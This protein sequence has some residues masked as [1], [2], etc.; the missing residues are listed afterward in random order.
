MKKTVLFLVTLLLTGYFGTAQVLY[1]EDFDNLT[2]GDV[3]TDFTG[4]Q[5]GQGG[6]YTLSQSLAVPADADN[7]YFKI[8]TEPNKGKVLQTTALPD[9]GINY[10]QTRGLDVLWSNRTTGN[11]VLKVE[12]DF[13]TGPHLSINGQNQ[14][15]RILS[16]NDFNSTNNNLITQVSYTP[17]LKRFDLRPGTL[18]MSPS[19]FPQLNQNTWYT[20]VFYIDYTNQKTYFLIPSLGV[21]A[22]YDHPDSIL[23][24]SSLLFYHS[25]SPNQTMKSDYKYDNISIS[26]VN[27]V[28][29]SVQDFISDKFSL[30]PNPSNNIIN[31]TNNKNIGVEQVTIFDVNG[32]LIKTKAFNKEHNVQIDVSAFAAGAYLVHIETNKGT[33]VKK[34][35]KN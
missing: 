18:N 3:G 26:A 10:I 17:S 24:P 1:S 27:T 28:P 25:T 7:K 11:D 6:W 35:I 16:N 30:Y 14:V 19:P 12:Y 31:I 4:Q 8:V 15:L 22:V 23:L 34:I 29:L 20:Y 9:L 32:K 33:A 21:K 13:F 2:L 5:A